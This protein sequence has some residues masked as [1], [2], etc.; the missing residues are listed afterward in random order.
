MVNLPVKRK[1]TQYQSKQI[2]TQTFIRKTFL[3]SSETSQST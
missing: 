2:N 3:I 1:N